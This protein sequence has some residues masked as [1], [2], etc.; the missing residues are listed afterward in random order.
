MIY[1][2]YILI[3]LN[4]KSNP[5]YV[6]YTNNIKNRLKLHNTSKGAKFT[7]GRIWKIIYKKRYQNKSIA[8]QNEYKI[9]HNYKLRAKIKTNYL[10]KLKYNEYCNTL[11]L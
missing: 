8:M 1:Y 3:N 7:R 6:G 4:K 9:K 5:T 2:V 11:T 10:N